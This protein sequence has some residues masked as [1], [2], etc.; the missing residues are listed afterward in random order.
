MCFHA[1]TVK[2]SGNIVANGGRVLS[3]TARGETL[4]E[5]QSS[6]YDMVK[7]ID[8]EE[9]FYRTDIGWRAVI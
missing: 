5:A 2:E 4:A 6:A 1:G 7:V 8:W 3:L 9:G